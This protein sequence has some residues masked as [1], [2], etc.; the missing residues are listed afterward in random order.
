MTELQVLAG[1]SWVALCAQGV[2][3]LLNLQFEG[4]E[5]AKDFFHAV[6]IVLVVVIH[7]GIVHHLAGIDVSAGSAL[8][9]SLDG[10]WVDNIA[11]RSLLWEDDKSRSKCQ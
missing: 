7:G 1:T 9:G 3:H 2:L 8:Y 10:E 11:R 6:V 5:R 4:V